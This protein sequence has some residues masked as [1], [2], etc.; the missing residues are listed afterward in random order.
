MAQPIRLKGAKE[1]NRL[2][3]KIG[4]DI[5]NAELFGEIGAFMTTSI[6]YRT[7]QGEDMYGD[8]FDEYSEK[9]AKKRADIGLPVNIVDLFY[10]GSM[11]G[12]LTWDASDEKV[13][14]F[15]MPGTDKSGV[16]NSLKAYYLNVK[17]EFFGISDVEREEILDLA[18]DHVDKLIKKG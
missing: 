14:V 18:A 3:K 10:T 2:F 16:E 9:Y 8:E 17:R 1:L 11:M 15:F 5:F 13:E 4:A 6:A 12:S 7:S